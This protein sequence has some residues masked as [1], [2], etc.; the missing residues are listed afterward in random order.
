LYEH[1]G[2]RLVAEQTGMTWGHTV[3]EQRFEWNA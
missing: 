1:A 2:F 3:T